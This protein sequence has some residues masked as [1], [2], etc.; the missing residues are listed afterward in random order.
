MSMMPGQGPAMPP[1]M[2]PGMP[3]AAP[4]G[5]AF[6][7]LD[8]SM[9]SNLLQPVAQLQAADQQALEAQQQAAVSSLLD[10]M[11]AMPNP[12]AQAAMTE[13]GQPTSPLDSPSP[14]SLGGAPQDMGGP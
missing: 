3:P 1:G 5:P 13:P 9:L 7:S 6:P 12:A 10:Q 14:G 8:P 11:R 4:T 2:I